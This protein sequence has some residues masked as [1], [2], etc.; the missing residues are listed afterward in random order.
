MKDVG[1]VMPVYKQDPVYLESALRSILQQSFKNYYFVIVSDGAP[2]ETVTVIKNVTKGDERVHL[3][4]KEKNKGVAKTLNVGFD[5]LMKIKEIKYLTW[6]SS[7]NI[8]FPNFVEK[9]REALMQGPE[10]LGLVYSSFRH[11]DEHGNHIL[12]N[13]LLAFRKFQEKP[14]EK[15]LDFCYIGASFMYKKQYAAM[16]SGYRMEPVEDYEYWLRLTEYCEIQYIPVEL[17]EYRAVS[18]HSISAQL[19]SSIEQ[20]RRWRYTFNL[21][22][23]QA[24][25]RRGIPFETTIILPIQQFS[26]KVVTQYENILEQSY[27]NYKLLILDLSTHENASSVLKEISDPRVAFFKYP[28][29]GLEK[30]LKYGIE[31]ADTPYTLLYGYDYFPKALDSLSNLVEVHDKLSC[32]IEYDNVVST[33][34]LNGLTPLPKQKVFQTNAGPIS[35]NTFLE[36]LKPN[37]CNLYRSK[38]L[39]KLISKG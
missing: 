3:I 19:Q 11:I 14:K 10:E 9:F 1:I 26:D 21:A 4:L 2:P 32:E 30:A 13:D 18:Q 12:N 28:N 33:F 17:M 37:F 23:Q 25:N 27:S 16:I 34:F 15:L 8:Y 22:R 39:K 29:A 6:V 5:Y 38:M 35:Y 20:H 36:Q 31:A 24:R 7:D